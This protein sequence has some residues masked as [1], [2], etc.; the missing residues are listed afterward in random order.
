MDRPKPVVVDRELGKIPMKITTNVF[1]L[2]VTKT[3]GSNEGGGR[4][5]QFH[6][7]GASKPM[8]RISATRYIARNG[9][10]DD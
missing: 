9:R 3:I 6:I 10:E 1:G 2:N 4:A 8:T 7:E 5:L